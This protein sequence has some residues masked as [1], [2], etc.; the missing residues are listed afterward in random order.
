MEF[1][2]E[3]AA[4]TVAEGLVRRKWT[5]VTCKI[6]DG[7]PRSRVLCANVGLYAGLER[8]AHKLRS[9]PRLAPKNGREPGAPRND[10]E[11]R[12]E[13]LGNAGEGARATL[14]TAPGDEGQLIPRDVSRAKRRE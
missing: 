5:L 4:R 14:P 11:C 9:N 3:G 8:A 1:S 10:A 12:W 13:F 2:E 6:I 7:A